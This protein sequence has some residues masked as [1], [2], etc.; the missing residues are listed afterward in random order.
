MSGVDEFVDY[1]PQKDFNQTPKYPEPILAEEIRST[2]VME[3]GEEKK[4]FFFESYQKFS[5]FEDKVINEKLQLEHKYPK[6]FL[7]FSIALIILGILFGLTWITFTPLIF[8]W[9]IFPEY[10]IILTIGTL[11]IIGNPNYPKKVIRTKNETNIDPLLS[12]ID[13]FNSFFSF[14]F[15]N[16]NFNFN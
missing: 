1:D 7:R 10:F 4:N 13:L 14:F 15:Y 9:F 16:F 3:G 6:L 12:K 11:F 8:P 2:S 5:S